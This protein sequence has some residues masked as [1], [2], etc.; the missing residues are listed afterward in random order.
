MTRK[1]SPYKVPLP[2]ALSR[3]VGSFYAEHIANAH[4]RCICVLSGPDKT[5]DVGW[6]LYRLHA[7]ESARAREGLSK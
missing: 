4:R 1:K 5:C 2:V 7:K 6:S 3:V